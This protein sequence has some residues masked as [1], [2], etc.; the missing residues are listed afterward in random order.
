MKGTDL[1]EVEKRLVGI[2]E[3]ERR[4][5]IGYTVLTILCTP[6]FV[7]M[8]SVVIFIVFAYVFQQGIYKPDALAIY[9]G[10]NIFL[11]YMIVFVLRQSN[12]PE[13]PHQFDKGW[14]AGVGL[15]L[16]LLILTYV[17][18]L[19]EWLPVSFG[20]VYTILGFLVLGLLGSVQMKKPV[21][22]D[23]GRHNV[24]MSLVLAVSGFIAMSY[25]EIMFSSWLWFPP[26][27]D[28]VKLCAWILCKLAEEK[29]WSL[30]NRAEY[31]RI[32]RILTRLKFIL[33]TENKI[34]LTAKGLDFVTMGINY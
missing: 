15:F 12:P 3:K 28:E 29:T 25:G 21:V 30:S 2:L 32:V 33:I 1:Q 34:E 7:A 16:I 31:E 13:E 20:I 24:F 4:E 23:T 17:S 8:A 5:A 26:K 18:G 11:A 19:R 22:E 27:P 6:A 14:L 10:I 9:T